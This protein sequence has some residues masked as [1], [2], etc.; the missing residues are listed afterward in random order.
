[1]TPRYREDLPERRQFIAI[2]ISREWREERLLNNL[3]VIRSSLVIIRE[4]SSGTDDRCF[5]A[6]W[7]FVAASR[8]FEY[9]RYASAKY[10]AV[11]GNAAEVYSAKE[12]CLYISR[13]SLE[14]P[15]SSRFSVPCAK[16]ARE[17]SA[18]IAEPRS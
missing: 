8:G 14:I 12:E 13:T 11:R 1:M 5:T 10:V 3:E 6:T 15:S 4:R 2:S 9:P 7:R 16:D 18:A 17:Q